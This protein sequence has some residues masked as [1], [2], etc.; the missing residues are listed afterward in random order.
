[1]VTVCH[2]GIRQ[3]G[4]LR[5]ALRLSW[6]LDETQNKYATTVYEKQYPDLICNFQIIIETPG[7]EYEARG[8]KFIQNNLI[9]L[10][11]KKSLA[12]IQF[13]FKDVE[14]PAHSA[15]IA[16]SSPI[17]AAM[18][19]TGKFKEGQTRTVNIKDIDIQVFRKLLQFLYTGSSGSSKNDS[20]DELQALY[21]AADKYQV[22]ALK[23]ICEECLIHQLD[24]ENVLDHLEWADLY[25]AEKLKEAVVTYM[26]KQ[27]FQVWQLEECED[28]NKKYPDLFY[29]I[30]KRMVHK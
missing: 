12:D 19:E 28:F 21:L 20:S 27:R 29:L 18:F 7:D 15:I 17:F 11:E 16:A 24:I 26:V 1:M 5:N 13:V 4:L 3:N 30:C 22:D 8:L 14:V 25:G 6:P 23:E 10:M 9:K 2:K